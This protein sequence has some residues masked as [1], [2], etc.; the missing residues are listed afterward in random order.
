MNPNELCW[1]IMSFIFSPEAST[2][3]QK[4]IS[5]SIPK[6]FHICTQIAKEAKR[7]KVNPALA[8][9]LAYHE[10]RFSYVTSKANAKGPLG[11]ITKYHCQDEPCDLIKAGVFALK[12]YLK[13]TNNVCDAIAQYNSTLNASCK[14]N[15]P[16]S[17]YAQRVLDTYYEVRNY[18]QQDC[19]DHP[20]TQ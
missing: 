15:S 16:A 13:R 10:S 5:R 14:D 2:T 4:K 11:V 17:H 9:A 6:R 12:K 3:Y 20:I 8:I 18:N 19:Y 1:I 7:Q